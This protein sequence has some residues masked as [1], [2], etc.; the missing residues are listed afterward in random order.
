[1]ASDFELSLSYALSCLQL[2]GLEVKDKQ[3]K[4][5]QSVYYCKDVIL[6]LPT[7]YGKF[8]CYQCRPTFRQMLVVV[9]SQL[10]SMKLTV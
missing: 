5:I 7:G 10:Q 4:A 2:E 6:W 9:P 3:R 1:M 8:L